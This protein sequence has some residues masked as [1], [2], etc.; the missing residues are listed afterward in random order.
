MCLS[1][2][3]VCTD[4]ITREV[5]NVHRA[6]EMSDRDRRLFNFAKLKIVQEDLEDGEVTVAFQDQDPVTVSAKYNP[7]AKV[8]IGC[9]YYDRPQI[10][11]K[12][13]GFWRT[14][15]RFFIGCFSFLKNALLNALAIG[16]GVAKKA[17]GWY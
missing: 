12:K 6:A 11:W 8:W 10:V 5:R 14:V 7:S 13:R 17:I 4:T 1:K 3:K 15:K 2:F 9:D 16:A